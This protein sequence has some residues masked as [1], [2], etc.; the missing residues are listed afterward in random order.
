[1]KKI[2]EIFNSISDKGYYILY[3]RECPTDVRLGI[4]S[5]GRKSSSKESIITMSCLSSLTTPKILKIWPHQQKK[6]KQ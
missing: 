5:K 4:D 3:D 6:A 2:N 1:M